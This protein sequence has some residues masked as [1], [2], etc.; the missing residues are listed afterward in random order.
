MQHQP[1]TILLATILPIVCSDQ[2]NAR[3]TD[4]KLLTNRVHLIP[5]NGAIFD[6]LSNPLFQMDLG[7][8]HYNSV[9]NNVKKLFYSYI[10][11]LLS[12][13]SNSQQTFLETGLFQKEVLGCEERFKKDGGSNAADSGYCKRQEVVKD[14][15]VINFETD[16]HIGN[17]HTMKK[18]T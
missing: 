11:N 16:P 8:Y 10:E 15:Q 14:S 2:L 4:A 5:T 9:L 18:S 12:Y 7:F 6:Q 13:G 3:S 1:T 17:K